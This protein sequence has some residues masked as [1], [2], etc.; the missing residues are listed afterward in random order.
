MPKRKVTCAECG[1]AKFWALL[2]VENLT[3]HPD[4]S[5]TFRAVDA[6]ANSRALTCSEEEHGEG[7]EFK[8]RWEVT[9]RPI[10]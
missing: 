7:E 4:G 3:E 2:S 9:M 8:G 10:R 5:F 6:E 1:D